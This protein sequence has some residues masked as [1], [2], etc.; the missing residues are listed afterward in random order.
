VKAT[1]DAGD[2]R[3]SP[4]DPYAS[5]VRA[6]VWLLSVVMV[7]V[8]ASSGAA[9][10]PSDFGI[11]LA[12]PADA[13]GRLT[14]AAVVAGVPFRLRLELSAVGFRGSASVVYDVQLPTGVHLAD[15]GSARAAAP[16]EGGLRTSSCLHACTIGWETGR[17]R[18][19]FVYYAL[20]VPVAA[21]AMLSAQITSTNRPDAHAADD[22]A[23]AIVRTVAPRLTLGVPQLVTGVPR[24][25][26]RFAFSFPV[27]LNGRAVQPDVVRCTASVAGT[28]LHGAV[29][30]ERGLAGCAWT[31]PPGTAGASLRTTAVV[32]ARSLRTSGSWLF[33]V[34]R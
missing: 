5:H 1:V 12:A 7:G 22:R 14:D 11:R 20:V 33:S 18:R 34:A 6:G 16:L 32:T 24:P 28:T 3:G 10:S 27:R 4:D 25:S 30:R 2:G 29:S 9:G 17:S 8:M 13:A 23:S 26:R 15:A 21:E 19:L 31:L